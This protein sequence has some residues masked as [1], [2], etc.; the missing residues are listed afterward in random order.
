MNPPF[1]LKQVYSLVQSLH[2]THAAMQVL[3]HKTQNIAFNAQLQLA[4]AMQELDQAQTAHFLQTACQL[5]EGNKHLLPECVAHFL[6]Q[7][8]K[9]CAEAALKESE[10]KSLSTGIKH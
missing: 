5:I 10:E 4:L 3:D 1:T 8:H 7:A 6:Q 2:T 9:Q